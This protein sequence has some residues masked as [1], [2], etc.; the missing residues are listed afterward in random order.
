MAY[1]VAY[2]KKTPSPLYCYCVIDLSGGA[3]AASYP[4]SYLADVP[5]GGWSDEYKTT[6]LVLRLVKPGTFM[7][8][9]SCQVTLTKPFYCGV[10]EV[11][12]KQYELVTGDKPSRFNNA[13]YYATRPVEQVS[14][15]MI[16][17]SSAG[18]GWP[19]SSAVDGNSFF[20]RV[21]LK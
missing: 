11:T 12:Q 3:D 16:R 21:R 1:T 2:M 7:M 8:N 15:D 10:F 13:S 19:G 6:K 5:S 4:V 18:A 14:Y 17:C 20:L 9:G